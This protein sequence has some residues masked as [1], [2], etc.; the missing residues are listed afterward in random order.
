[1]DIGLPNQAYQAGVECA[2]DP[3]LSTVTTCAHKWGPGS[4]TVTKM[5]KERAKQRRNYLLLPR[6]TSYSG[7]LV[8][9]QHPKVDQDTKAKHKKTL[10]PYES[11]NFN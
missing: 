1:M 7:W 4:G 9:K 5:G 11:G 2:D 6:T 3:S 8:S 10:Q